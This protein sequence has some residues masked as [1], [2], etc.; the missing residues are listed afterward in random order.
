LLSN[1]IDQHVHVETP[2]FHCVICYLAYT[3]SD[4][5]QTFTVGKISFSQVYSSIMLLGLNKGFRRDR[6]SKSQNFDLGFARTTGPPPPLGLSWHW[7]YTYLVEDLEQ[8]RAAETLLAFQ[9]GPSAPQSSLPIDKV[10]RRLKT[11]LRLRIFRGMT[12][13][14]PTADP[15][16]FL[17]LVN[18]A[19]VTLPF[20]STPMDNESGVHVSLE[21]STFPQSSE[22]YTLFSWTNSPH[23]RRWKFT[24]WREMKSRD[25]FW[26][27]DICKQPT[28]ST[29]QIIVL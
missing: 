22:I 10:S 24:K 25:A 11:S 15:R 8:I 20:H 21:H 28:I 19:A 16:P 5:F 26:Q 7:I 14:S 3:Y 9:E 6:V 13:N 4:R 17:R 12:K 2:I 29:R 27:K 23:S 1:D 18:P